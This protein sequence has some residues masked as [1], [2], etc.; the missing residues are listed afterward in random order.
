MKRHTMAEDARGTIYGLLQSYADNG[1]TCFS[2]KKDTD[3][4]ID[5]TFSDCAK[6]KHHIYMMKVIG[7][8]Q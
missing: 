7:R 1:N 8:Y 6:C 3:E 5:K 2:N 4:C